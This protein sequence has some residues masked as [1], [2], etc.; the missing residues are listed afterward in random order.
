MQIL[1]RSVLSFELELVFHALHFK[2]E[3]STPLKSERATEPM[4]LLVLLAF[5]RPY[6]DQIPITPSTWHRRFERGEQ[7]KKG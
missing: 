3:G 7:A 6:S 1:V 4:D 2:G 5:V